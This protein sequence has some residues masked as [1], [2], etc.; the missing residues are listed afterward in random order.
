MWQQ[1]EQES[2]PTNGF[3]EGNNLYSTHLSPSSPDAR[4][5]PLPL[6]PPPSTALP[7]QQRAKRK[8]SKD[9]DAGPPA[10]RISCPLEIDASSQATMLEPK[11]EETA[12]LTDPAETGDICLL[13]KMRQECP[14]SCRDPNESRSPP[15]DLDFP[16]DQMVNHDDLPDFTPLDEKE[17]RTWRFDPKSC[18][19]HVVNQWMSVFY[20]WLKDQPELELKAEKQEVN[21][22]TLRNQLAGQ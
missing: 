10:K 20:W 1:Y 2:D 17:R 5:L 3:R 7:P 4:H 6:S 15:S 22:S 18:A 13:E 21:S 8:R 19:E 9:F 12:R 16:N 14:A 11:N